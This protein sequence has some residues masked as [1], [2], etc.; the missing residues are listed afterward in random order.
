M[1]VEKKQI[2]TIGHNRYLV[3]N[4][5][6]AEA[7]FNELSNLKELSWTDEVSGDTI[8]LRLEV[9]IEILEDKDDSSN[10]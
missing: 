3:P 5:V 10:N 4:E 9:D 7:L 8:R 1:K 6:N 2:L